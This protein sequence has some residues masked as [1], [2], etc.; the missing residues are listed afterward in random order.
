MRS[1]IGE[2]AGIALT[3]SRY[4]IAENIA[5]RV[6]HDKPIAAQ[7]TAFIIADILDGVVMRQFDLDTKARRVADGVIDHLSVARVAKEVFAK[8][9]VSQP[10][11]AVLGARAVAVGALDLIHLE[12]TGEAT[13]GQKNQKLT[14][15]ATAIFAVSANTRSENLTHASGFVAST[16]ALSTAP[17]HL[18]ELGVKHENGIRE[19]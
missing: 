13:K 7:L 14:N 6:K 5:Q 3:C 15:L 16:I 11:I 8:N 12:R 4:A 1:K 10:Y 19:L 18:K 17:A 9:E 2:Y